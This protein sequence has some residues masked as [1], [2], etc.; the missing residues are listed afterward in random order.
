[1]NDCILVDAA[2]YSVSAAAFLMGKRQTRRPSGAHF[3]SRCAAIPADE[4]NASILGGR[5]GVATD[6]LPLA[7]QG[8]ADVQSDE[9]VQTIEGCGF[10]A[11]REG[12]IVEDRIHEIRDLALE[13]EYGLA[14]VQELSC[15]FTKNVNA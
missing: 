3:W 2:L 10:V 9:A 15:I 4:R 8:E 14:D 5:N 12:G 6:P 7:D 13:Q 1:M 11:L